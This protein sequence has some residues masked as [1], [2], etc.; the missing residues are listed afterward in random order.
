MEMDSLSTKQLRDLFGG[1]I[2]TSQVLRGVASGM[3]A[4]GVDVII[5]PRCTV[6]HADPV[7]KTIV[8]PAMVKSEKALLIVRWHVDHEAGHIIFSPDM[9]PILD[10]WK[11]KSKMK[12]VCVK[13]DFKGIPKQ[14]LT[15]AQFFLNYCEDSRVE[16]LMIKRFP[17][18]RR[19]FIGGPIAADCEKIVED[20]VEKATELAKELG[21]PDPMLSPFFVGMVHAFALLDGHHGQRELDYCREVIPPHMNW[22]MDL[23]E[24]EF[25]DIKG[26]VSTLSFGDLV[27][28]TDST[29]AKIMDK[30]LEDMTD[31]EE[32]EDGEDKEKGEG[33]GDMP[34]PFTDEFKRGKD[35]KSSDGEPDED[36]DEEEE[37]SDEEDDEEGIEANVEDDEEEEEESDK[38]E[39]EAGSSVDGDSEDTSEGDESESDSEKES[40]EKEKELSKEVEDMLKESHMDRSVMMQDS[41]TPPPDSESVP[42]E[43]VLDDYDYDGSIANMPEGYLNRMMP[44]VRVVTLRDRDID[45]AF[46]LTTSEFDA[47]DAHIR[48]LMPKNLGPAARHLV[49]EFRGAPGRAWTGNRINPRMLQRIEAGT[50]YGQPI[51]MRKVE[52]ML[53]KRGVAVFLLVDYSGSMTGTMS[54]LNIGRW[55]TKLT[56]SHAAARGI[57][58]LLSPV[59]VPFA[60]GGF[61]TLDPKH[62]ERSA[63]TGR[64]HG[65]FS[66]Y[67]DVLNMLFKDFHDPWTV[68]ER[69]MLALHEG[70]YGKYDGSDISC[71]NNADGESVLWAATK[72]LQRQEQKKLLVVI[73]DGYPQAGTHSE[74]EYAYLKW[75]V[76]RATKAGLIVG[77]FGLGST[78]VEQFYPIF[79]VLKT[80]PSGM[81]NEIMAPI[82]IQE[83]ILSLIEKMAFKGE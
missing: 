77:G 83:K 1:K 82:Y 24:E 2:P 33:S 29:M 28:M 64:Y 78:A 35:E 21:K 63:G 46:D 8:L 37:D 72:L 14:L 12:E 60:V 7:N 48:S 58:R 65:G 44:G 40:E 6:P 22:V 67:D 66:R 20:T 4:C 69:R 16:H 25:L 42:H 68:S 17:G 26:K 34:S 43:D 51:M 75:A 32:E 70:S 81:G 19:N 31:E 55:N 45:E 62:A 80:F 49:G 52:T 13:H 39:G 23:V 41:D 79:E 57:A 15:S 11:R 5:D 59:R 54:G 3:A 38:D 50:A 71:R 53:S 27:E 9:R 76:Q 18:C 36:S 56:V 47:Y 10:K 30:V 73:S 74:S 61:T